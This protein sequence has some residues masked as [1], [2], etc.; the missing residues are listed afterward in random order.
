MAAVLIYGSP[1]PRF[2][3]A[4]RLPVAFDLAG[5]QRGMA[6]WFE[7]VSDTELRTALPRGMPPGDVTVRVLQDGTPYVPVAT[8]VVPLAP[9][10]FTANSQGNGP[11]LL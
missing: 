10:I 3:D 11:A 5:G 9:G 4:E 8:R 6:E 7:R 2:T 1:G